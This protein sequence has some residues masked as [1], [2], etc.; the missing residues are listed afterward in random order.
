MSND[1]GYKTLY[2]V[3]IFI[4]AFSIINFYA[5]KMK[6]ERRFKIES[7]KIKDQRILDQANQ[8]MKEFVENF[9]FCQDYQ[10]FSCHH[11]EVFMSAS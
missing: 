4:L 3:L 11:L 1:S 9:G 10:K 7:Q 8:K 5:S 6:E 2:S